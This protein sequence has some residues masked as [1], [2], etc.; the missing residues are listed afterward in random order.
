VSRTDVR[1]GLQAI[2]FRVWDLSRAEGR[3]TRADTL[4]LDIREPPERDVDISMEVKE[5][6]PAEVTLTLLAAR[7]FG[8]APNTSSL[9]RAFE[10]QVVAPLRDWV[11]SHRGAAK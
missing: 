6:S 7:T 9:Q 11:A 3:D 5:A 2:G 1:N 4:A 8:P 10:K